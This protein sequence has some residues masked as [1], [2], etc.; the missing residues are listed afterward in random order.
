MMCMYRWGDGSAASRVVSLL[1][2]FLIQVRICSAGS[3]EYEVG[4]RVDLYVNKLGPYV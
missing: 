4:E 1:V 2:L 3:H